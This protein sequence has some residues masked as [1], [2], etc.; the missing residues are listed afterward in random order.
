MSLGPTIEGYLEYCRNVKKLT[1]NTVKDIKCGIN[2]LVIY[3]KKAGVSKEC[4]ELTLPEYIRWINYCREEGHSP[5]HINKNLSHV[6][7]LIGY[8]WRLEKVD[9][10]VL[11][12]YYIQDSDQRKEVDVLTVEEAR[13]IVNAFSVNSRDERRNRL[14]MLLLY[15]CGLR[16]GELCGLSVQD[17]D[18]ERREIK[19]TGKGKERVIPVMDGVYTEILAYLHDRRTSKGPMFKTL[20]KKTRLRIN[21]VIKIVDEASKRAGLNKRPTPKSIRH[22]FASHLADRGVD[23]AVIA[24]LM[25]HR[26]PRETSVYLH[27]SKDRLNETVFENMNNKKGEK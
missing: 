12:G 8:V 20:I 18:Q 7:G 9:R 2:R 19:V 15:G 1:H 4:W 10:N 13:R 27:A 21:D 14:I 24:K 16:N 22:T 25:G 23:I 11:E 17:I 5:K 3:C 6:R 26:S